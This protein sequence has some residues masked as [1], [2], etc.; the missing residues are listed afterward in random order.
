[1]HARQ[2][3]AFPVEY[4]FAG[5]DKQLK[6]PVWFLNLPTSQALHVFCSVVSYPSLHLQSKGALDPVFSV[7]LFVVHGV[8]AMSP[9]NDLNW[10]RGQG[11]H[12]A[13]TKVNP[14]AHKQSL[15]NALPGS[16]ISFA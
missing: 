1:M 2:L 9:E 6:F 12:D 11:V 3:T 4:V 5:H 7:R 16:E 10:C 15:S 8:Q 14:F 13:S